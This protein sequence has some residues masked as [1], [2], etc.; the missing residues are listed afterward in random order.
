MS[1]TPIDVSASIMSAA[2]WEKR[3]RDHPVVDWMLDFEEAFDFGDMKSG[4]W[5]A[6]VT[7][8]FSFTKPTGECI[9]GGEPAWA[10]VLETYAPFVAH[11][12]EPF[13]SAQWETPTGYELIGCAKMFVKLPVPGKDTTKDQEGREWDV[14]VPG[15]FHFEYTKDPSGPKGLKMKSQKIFADGIPLVSEMVKRGMVT[16]DQVLSPPGK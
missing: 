9:A 12:H 3:F 4:P 7:D 13:F 2:A 14:G 6:W 5:N 8:D 11:Y 16:A 1:S 10:A 15:A